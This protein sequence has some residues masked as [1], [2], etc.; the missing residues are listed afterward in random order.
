VGWPINP[1]PAASLLTLRDQVD[2]LYPG[3]NRASDGLIG[4]AAHQAVQSDHNPN[5]QGIVTAIDITHDPDHG[6][7]IQKLATAL[8]NSLDPRI[9]Y[10][11]ANRQIWE[12]GTGWHRY[13]GDNPHNKHLHLSVQGN[14]DDSKLWN[15]K[16]GQM[17]EVQKLREQLDLITYKFN[18]SEK[19]L[20]VR[21]K[22]M[23]ILQ[24]K[25]N[26]SE[27]ALRVREKQVAELQKGINRE[28]VV[29]Y[30]TKNLK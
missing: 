12:R 2:K 16:G 23:D 7:D 21:A 1:R 15:L 26:E 24:Y 4:D 20:K 17:D 9:K 28:T 8:V 19:A 10:I 29:A 5:A 6:L 27:K 18:E 22:E 14:V 3:R 30:I 13:D 25:F 11:I